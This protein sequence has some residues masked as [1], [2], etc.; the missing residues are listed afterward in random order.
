MRRSPGELLDSTLFQLTHV[1][2]KEPQPGENHYAEIGRHIFP[3]VDVLDCTAQIELRMRE[4]VALELSMIDHTEFVKEAESG[5][6][7]F[8]TLSSIR[9]LVRKDATEGVS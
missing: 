7:A 4:K 3:K 8:P 1:R 6:V 2:I 5:G 9:V